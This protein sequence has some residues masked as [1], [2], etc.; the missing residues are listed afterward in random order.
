MN[1][2][3]RLEVRDIVVRLLRDIAHGGEPPGKYAGLCYNMREHIRAYALWRGRELGRATDWFDDATEYISNLSKQAFAAWPEF[4]GD[5]CYPIKGRYV[6]AIE[7]YN[8]AS[9]NADMYADDWY[10]DSRRRLAGFLAEYFDE[11]IHG[12]AL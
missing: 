7:A 12:D 6:S 10:G 8:E 9:D 5:T 3:E 11:A 1:A 4:S 2:L